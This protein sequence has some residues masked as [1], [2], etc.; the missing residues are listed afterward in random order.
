MTSY[1]VHEKVHDG[2]TVRPRPSGEY[3]GGGPARDGA[4][5]PPGR[6]DSHRGDAQPPAMATRRRPDRVRVQDGRTGMGLGSDA[7]PTRVRRRSRAGRHAGGRGG[8]HGGVPGA[9]QDGTVPPAQGKERRAL[10]AHA[11]LR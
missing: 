4:D 2:R 7:P 6:P 9:E 1:F 10:R 3:P 8:S 5:D 11:V